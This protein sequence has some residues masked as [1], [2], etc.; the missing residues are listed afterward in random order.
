MHLWNSVFYKESRRRCVV[1]VEPLQIPNSCFYKDNAG[2]PKEDAGLAREEFLNKGRDFRPGHRNLNRFSME[3]LRDAYF[4]WKI[5]TR[6]TGPYVQK[7]TVGGCRKRDRWICRCPGGYAG[8]V[9]RSR[10][11]L[12]ASAVRRRSR[13]GGQPYGASGTPVR[14]RRS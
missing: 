11:G 13:P 14:K 12:R 5:P 3:G 10:P 2:V 6:R 1:A 8:H 9:F 7:S 4:W